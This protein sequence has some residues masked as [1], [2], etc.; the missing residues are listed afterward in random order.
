M[1]TTR[2]AGSATVTQSEIS[3]WSGGNR[4]QSADDSQTR[5]SMLS[6]PDISSNSWQSDSALLPPAFAGQRVGLMGG[7]FNPPHEGHAV[8]AMTALR[9]LALD[10]LW[11]M[12]T[13]GNPL[14]SGDG[15]PSLAM[16]M[17]ASRKLV[18]DPRIKVTGFEASLGSAYTYETVRFLTR[19]LPAVRFVWIMGADN[20]ATFHRWQH[21]RG[22]AKL[23]P[24]A[25][26]DRP[27]WRHKALA[28]PAAG[29]MAK[30]RVPEAQAA[31]LP[32][33]DAP[34]WTFLSTRLSEAS[35]TAIRDATATR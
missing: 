3:D 2:C 34:A 12:V 23:V 32:F 18:S 21:W 26:V 15:L 19:R 10:Q 7:T 13:P 11:W 8:C 22:I 6:P 14:K 33:M 28:S 4:L 30:F 35:S 24:M 31:R 9:R 27:G 17:A 29:R 5:Q 20:L 1:R 25:I 16:R